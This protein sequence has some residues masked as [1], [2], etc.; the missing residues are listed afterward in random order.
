MKKKVFFRWNNIWNISLIILIGITVYGFIFEREFFLSNE[1]DS[2]F[3]KI[4]MFVLYVCCLSL[5]R[6][7]I[8][9]EERVYV[10]NFIGM[11]LSV[12]YW[13]NCTKCFVGKILQTNAKHINSETKYIIVKDANHKKIRPNSTKK[14]CAVIIEYSKK[15]KEILQKLYGKN[16]NENLNIIYR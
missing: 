14:D 5:S 6:L 12:I 13:K 1:P 10:C 11:T 2:T 16:I 3:I 7:V 15:R 4:S 9:D 8:V